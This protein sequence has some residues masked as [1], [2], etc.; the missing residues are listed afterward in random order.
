MR[1]GA[2][3]PSSFLHRSCKSTLLQS[4]AEGLEP[5]NSAVRKQIAIFWSVLLR[6]RHRLIYANSAVSGQQLSSIVATVSSPP[7]MLHAATTFFR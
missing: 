4:R 2:I 6:P 1:G 3:H 5:L 7:S